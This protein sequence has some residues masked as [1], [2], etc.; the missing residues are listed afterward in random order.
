MSDYEEISQVIALIVH[1][2]DHQQWDRLDAVFTE[3]GTFVLGD[4]PTLATALKSSGYRTGAFVGAFVLDARF[5]LNRGFDAYDDRM[6]GS[7]ADL[8]LV[9]RTP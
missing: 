3:D 5:G 2:V 9:Q 4:V 7:S 8:E 1:L 6:T